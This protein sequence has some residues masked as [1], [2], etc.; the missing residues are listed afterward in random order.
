MNAQDVML[1]LPHVKLAIVEV[2]LTVFQLTNAL[3]DAHQLVLNTNA[4]GRLA[5]QL[6]FKTMLVHRANLS[7]SKHVNQLHMVNATLS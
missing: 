6:V 4:A 5:H 7:A 2:E 1:L 3:K